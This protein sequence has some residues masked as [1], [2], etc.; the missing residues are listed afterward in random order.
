LN[1]ELLKVEIWAQMYE[2]AYANGNEEYEW[3]SRIISFN[4]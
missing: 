3:N 1:V 4:S 2:M